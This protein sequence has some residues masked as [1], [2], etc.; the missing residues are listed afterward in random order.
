M[1]HMA[2]G[3][4]TTLSPGRSLARAIESVEKYFLSFHFQCI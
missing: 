1:Y 2:F 3:I 4:I